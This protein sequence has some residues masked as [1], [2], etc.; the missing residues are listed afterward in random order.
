MMIPGRAV[1]N[2]H[3]QLVGGALDIDRADARALEA[4]FQFTAQPSHPSCNKSSVIR[5]S[6]YQARLP[7]L[8]VAQAEIRKGAFFLVPLL[9]PSF[10]AA[11]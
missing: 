1:V 3:H 11:A 2:A 8:V 9:S 7:R 10:S 6:A 5:G 4:L